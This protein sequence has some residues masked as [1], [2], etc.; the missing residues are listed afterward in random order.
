MTNPTLKKVIQD[1]EGSLRVEFPHPSINEIVWNG[2]SSPAP[3]KAICFDI[4]KGLTI[5]GCPVMSLPP[6]SP[7]WYELAENL[8]N[9][10]QHLRVRSVHSREMELAKHFAQIKNKLWPEIAS[11]VEASTI[12][13]FTIQGPKPSFEE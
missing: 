9:F 2:G 7:L 12:P 6:C 3:A 4:D 5:N 13:L 11:K 1:I 10:V 8:G